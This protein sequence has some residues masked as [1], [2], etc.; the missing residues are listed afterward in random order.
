MAGRREL[1]EHTL[2]GALHDVVDQVLADHP[3]LRVRVAVTGDRALGDPER[4]L[5]AAAR[6]ALRN[7]ARHGAGADVTLFGQLDAG[8]AEVYVRDNGPGFVLETVPAE[9]RGVRDSI[10]ARMR[11]VDG[12]AQIESLPGFGTEVTLRLGGRAS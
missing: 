8:A 7:A 5:A 6:E 11:A 1:G 2:A 3:A 10:I 4:A 12:T 9:R